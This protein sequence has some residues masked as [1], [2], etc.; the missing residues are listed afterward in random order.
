MSSSFTT[1]KR[2]N[3][4]GTGDNVSSWGGVLNAGALDVIDFALDG[5][6]TLAISGDH[7]LSTADGTTTG[8][9]AGARVLKLTT[10]TST[11]TQTLPAREGWYLVWNATTVAQT[12]ACAGGGTTVSVA[13]GE[14]IFVACDATNVKRLT[15]LQQSTTLDMG[16]FKI[17]NLGAPAASTDAATKA[18]VDATAFNMAAGS[19]PGQT[20][21]ANRF[22]FTNGSAASWASVTTSLISDY[23]TDQA[24][25]ATAATALAIAFAVSL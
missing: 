7:T 24:T 11:Y 22:L 25:R 20:G 6:T 17:T 13:A 9:E 4:Q 18:Y 10:A 19:L 5:W 2:A 8:N 21:N 15:V 12:I 1:R 3:K 14:I 23:S 16:G